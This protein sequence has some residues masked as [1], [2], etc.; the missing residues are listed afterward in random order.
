MKNV[1]IYT[2]NTCPFCDRAKA[3]FNKKGWK[4]EEINV[5]D[6]Q[7]REDMIKKANGQ[8]TV[9]QIFIDSYHV[10]GCDDLYKLELEKK[11]DDLVKD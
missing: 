11:L 2:T 3:L 1:I 4:Y 6:P 7:K 5:E 8:R 10:G 9:P